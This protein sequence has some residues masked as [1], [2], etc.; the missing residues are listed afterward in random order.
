MY[1]LVGKEGGWTM[2]WT[3]IKMKKNNQRV[4]S[5]AVVTR[6]WY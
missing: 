6:L 4:S 2:P 1:D 3:W 5:M